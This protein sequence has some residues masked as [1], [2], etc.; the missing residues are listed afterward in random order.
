MQNKEAEAKEELKRRAKQLE[1]Q[2]RE[3]QRRAA[4]T[5]GSGFA[6][7]GSGSMPSYSR[8]PLYEPTLEPAR[9]D[10][11]S[12]VSTSRTPAF[13][14]SGMKLGSKKKQ[15]DLLDALGGEA[16]STPELSVPSTPLAPSTPE[17]IVAKGGINRGSLPS[18]QV[19]RYAI[20]LD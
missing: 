17:P 2:R 3:Q 4:A 5:G 6:G 19:E 12:S 14:G 20:K 18:I 7:T 13:K 1:M 8:V 16:L 9:T 15:T 11:P 10:S